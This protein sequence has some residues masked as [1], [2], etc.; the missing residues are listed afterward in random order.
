MD[1]SS[2]S[3]PRLANGYKGDEI[4]IL[5]VPVP[6]KPKEHPKPALID[7]NM[8]IYSEVTMDHRLSGS[9]PNR[10]PSGTDMLETGSVA[11]THKTSTKRKL[12]R[13]S[14][15]DTSQHAMNAGNIVGRNMLSG[16]MLEYIRDECVD[17]KTANGLKDASGDNPHVLLGW[18]V[19]ILFYWLLTIIVIRRYFI[20]LFLDSVY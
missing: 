8:S 4:P 10:R 6:A 1:E 17:G 9:N 5:H 16:N 18:Q 14:I 3:L 11:D 20:L 2:Y 7:D 13:K 12:N 15:F 19:S